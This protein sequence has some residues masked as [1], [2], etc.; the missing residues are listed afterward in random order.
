MDVQQTSKNFIDRVNNSNFSTFI[1]HP[2]YV[3]ILLTVMVY[4][5]VLSSDKSSK[6]FS[7]MMIVNICVIFLHNNLILKNIRKT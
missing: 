3:S 5:L 6:L 7:H 4:A 1:R 2:I